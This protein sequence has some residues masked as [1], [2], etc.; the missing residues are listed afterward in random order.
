M[1]ADHATI[2][3]CP[4]C[5]Y[6]GW[7]ISGRSER[8]HKLWFGLVKLLWEAHQNPQEKW[9]DIERLRYWLTVKAGHYEEKLL[10]KQFELNAMPH[11]PSLIE[12]VL[13]GEERKRMFAVMRT[14]GTL[15]V[16]RAKS[17]AWHKMR[18]EEFI[19]LV[20]RGMDIVVSMVPEMPRS[21]AL[22]ALKEITGLNAL[23]WL[24]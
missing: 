16:R 6:R 19:E 4:V 8:R 3:Y 13:Q 14:N 21:H 23:E 24:E 10:L 18:E 2:T 12:A 11:L 9:E 15:S 20:N 17:I 7:K 22:S 1:M 5:G